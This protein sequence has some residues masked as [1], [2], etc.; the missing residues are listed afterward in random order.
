MLG[1][2]MSTGRRYGIEGQ[3]YKAITRAIDEMASDDDNKLGL[4]VSYTA[5]TDEKTGKKSPVWDSPVTE[6]FPMAA[7]AKLADSGSTYDQISEN[8]YGEG[9]DHALNVEQPYNGWDEYDDDAFNDEIMEEFGTPE[10]P[11]QAAAKQ[12]EL[13]TEAKK[14]PDLVAVRHGGKITGW[15][16]NPKYTGPALGPGGVL[17]DTENNRPAKAQKPKAKPTKKR[18]TKKRKSHLLMK[19]PNA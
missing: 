5:H 12:L 2:A 4:A 8:Q 19:R 10:T 9:Q 18:K 13:E 3:M 15:M 1:R 17:W 16:K 7:A 11:A 6:Y 14:R